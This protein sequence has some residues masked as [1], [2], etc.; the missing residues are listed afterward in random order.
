MMSPFEELGNAV[1]ILAVKD[2]RDATAKLKHG[3]RNL[4]AE[5]TKA[6]CEDF[7][8]SPQFGIYT[9]VDGKMILAKLESEVGV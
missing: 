3:R 8:K 2:W 4:M 9:A 1:V 6:E 7:F 5:F